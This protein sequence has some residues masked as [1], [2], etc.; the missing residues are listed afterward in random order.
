M[1]IENETNTTAYQISVVV[2]I[3]IITYKRFNNPTTNIA[4]ETTKVNKNNIN[5]AFV[6][7]KR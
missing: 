6:T 3:A 7:Y 2:K 4:Y 1:S 5:V